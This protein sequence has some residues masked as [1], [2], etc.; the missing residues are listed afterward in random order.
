MVSTHDFDSCST[1]SNPVGPTNKPKDLIRTIDSACVGVKRKGMGLTDNAAVLQ[2][3]IMGSTPI[4]ATINIQATKSTT[5]VR[6]FLHCQQRMLKVRNVLEYLE[7]RYRY[8][9]S[10]MP[11][12]GF[13]PMCPNCSYHQGGETNGDVCSRGTSLNTVKV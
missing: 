13:N 6:S 11:A 10:L 7:V 9:V 8:A 5:R 4:Y 1:G 3:V 12:P 2:A